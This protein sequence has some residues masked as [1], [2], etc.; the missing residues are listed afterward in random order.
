MEA[1][2]IFGIID[3]GEEKSFGDCGVEAYEEV[4]TIPYQ[5]ISLVVSDS[6]FINY[7][8]LPRNQA[9]RYLLGHQQIIERVMD[10]HTI[11]PMKLGTY[12]LNFGEIDE[13]L[14]KGYPLFKEVF[15][16]IN[17]TTEIDVAATWNDLDS[18]VKE[19][20]EG[21]DMK[22]LKEKLLSGPEGVSVEDRQGAGRLIKNALDKK[23][24]RLAS[25]IE[26]ELGRLSM[27]VKAHAL[28]DDTMILNTA[29]LIDKSK[30]TEFERRLDILNVRCNGKINFRCIGPLP[31]YSFS[32][33]EVKKI[34]SEEIEWAREKLGIDN[35]AVA[36]ADITRAYRRKASLFHPD[37]NAGDP[38]AAGQ[39]DEIRR[40]YN[41][42]LE[43]LQGNDNY[44]RE[45][46]CTTCDA[47]IVR[48]RS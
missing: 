12:A 14:S 16:K 26:G 35:I 23:R 48:M 25:E 30:K 40:A 44:L 20:G 10:S 41:I 7:A 34:C 2:Y 43:C 22:K 15:G 9:A 42:L 13:I 19:I 24:E 29:F 28:M 33:A 46:E 38:G 21:E 3:T 31:P 47:I 39:F 5:D 17:N 45:Q 27:D 8:N 1:K 4:Y 6:Q 32:T 11:I 37:R 36:V 18:I